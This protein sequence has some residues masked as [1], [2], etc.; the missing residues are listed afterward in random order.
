MAILSKIHCEFLKT[1]D[2][3]GK[4]PEL[5]Y[6]GNQKKTS[7]VGRIFSIS[8]IIIY[9]IF[10]IYK[11]IR[12]LKKTDVSFYDTFTYAPEPPALKITKENFFAGFALE[13]PKTYDVFI[14]ESIY[15]P[16]AYFKK[17]VNKGDNFEWQVKEIELERCKLENFGSLYQ[18]KFKTKPLHN[19]Y[20][21][22]EMDFVLEG[23]FSY[24]IYSLFYIQFFPCVNTTEKKNCKPLEVID[25]Y[26]KKT[27]ISFQFQDIELTPNKYE[28]PFRPR[29]TDLYTTI[30]KKIFKEIHAYFQLVD[31][32]T[33]MDWIGFDEFENIKSE[34][35]LKYDYMEIMSNI[36][37]DD[38]FE[39]GDSFC[40]FT[41]KLSENVRTERRT[42]TKLIA[43]LGNIGGLMEVVY[44]LFK[45]ISSFSVNIL[46]EISLVNNLFS[47]DLSNKIVILKDKKNTKRIR[48][49]KDNEEESKTYTPNNTLQRM[50]IQ[51][52]FI[53]DD[54]NLKSGKWLKE[55]IIT[56]R[57][58]YDNENIDNFEVMKFPKKK[59]FVKT[60]SN[61]THNE[62]KNKML[63]TSN[64][65]N[66]YKSQNNLEKK[67]V[68]YYPN[69]N[70]KY[71]QKKSREQNRGVID[72]II[73]KRSCIYF[74]FCYVRRRKTT[75]NI[76]LDEGMSIIA[77]KMDIFNIFEK[78]FKYEE[79]KVINK[80][81]IEMSDESKIK[82]KNLDLKIKEK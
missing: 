69:L 10:F 7:W 22:K 67:E 45:M 42:Y 27:F 5:Y 68:Q 36:M 30:G 4:D 50:P 77:E 43:I 71:N 2:M 61:F 74:L 82:L 8:F 35:Y 14:D 54:M 52:T 44:T 75:E 6:K 24:D 3:F 16:K 26:L 60:K 76:L 55:D 62:S 48:L 12:M 57:N 41:I 59:S 79:I 64:N 81:I 80:K 13:D 53:N 37:D 56:F 21:F 39:N 20:C 25:Y 51:S 19:L 78:M 23:H 73:I 31:I 70:N 40:D 32:Q 29:D 33:D 66:I 34:K 9:F 49:M 17:G 63:L 65:I 58:Q 1:V 15:I 28:T 18:E 47:F 72:K 11:L 38:I 46:Y